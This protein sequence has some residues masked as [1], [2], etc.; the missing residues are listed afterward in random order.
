MFIKTLRIILSVCSG[1]T[2]ISIVSS[3]KLE[4]LNISSL[5]LNILM[6]VVVCGLLGIFMYYFS[7]K[8]LFGI[9]K[10]FGKVEK[11][12]LDISLYDVIVIFIGLLLGLIVANLIAIPLKNI[13]IIGGPIALILNVFFSF[14]GMYLMYKKRDEITFTNFRGLI[15]K[16]SIKVVDTCILIDGR[17]NEIVKTGFIKGLFLIPTFILMELQMLADSNDETKR[18]KGKRGLE[19]LEQLKNDYSNIIIKDTE[20][21]RMNVET[22]VKLI[23]Y[24]QKHKCT[25]VTLDYNLNKVAAVTGI[26]VLNVN[27]LSNSLKS[28]AIP[29]EKMVVKIHKKGK[30]A[31]QGI[32]YLDD[33]T[34]VIV[35]NGQMFIGKIK[36]VKVTSVT[37]TSAGRLIFTKVD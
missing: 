22:D 28:S 24:A 35:E 3:L 12:V 13:D 33:G 4:Y 29:G 8:I 7:G 27:D 17:L 11:K 37:Q 30:E 14:M 20:F 18:A 2:G 25:I 16:E 6:Y 21:D 36:E 10:L 23:K 9:N 31:N 32:G 15:A 19:L 34:M 5:A 26:K 1:I